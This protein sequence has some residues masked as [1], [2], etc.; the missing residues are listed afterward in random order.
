ML[1]IIIFFD[2][3]EFIKCI[4]EIILFWNWNRFRVLGRKS[5]LF[6]LIFY[7]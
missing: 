4:G 2:K 3:E 1:G 5:N 7:K 6:K